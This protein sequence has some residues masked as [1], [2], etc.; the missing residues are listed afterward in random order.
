M[1]SDSPIGATFFAEGF[2]SLSC[3]KATSLF[4]PS[5]QPLLYGR[6]HPRRK[7]RAEYQDISLM[8][9]LPRAISNAYPLSDSTAHSAV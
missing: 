5:R 2:V 7:G 8:L 3:M 1:L 4:Y 9:S 6:R